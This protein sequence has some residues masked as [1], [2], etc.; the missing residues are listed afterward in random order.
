MNLPEPADPLFEIA[1]EE[2]TAERDRI[3]KR[4]KEQG[5][6]GAAAEI[7]ALKRPSITAY[8]LNLVARRDSDLIGSLLEADERM[9]TAKSRAD[10]DGAKAD[11]QKAISAISGKAI[12]VLT[13]QGRSVTPQVKERLTETLLAVATDDP[14]RELLEHGRLLKEAKAGAFGG[15]VVVF[16]AVEPDDERRK[17]NQR[18]SRLR[19]EGEAKLM[20]AKK[21]RTDSD[22]ARHEAD[23]LAEA[24]AAAAERA[25][26]MANLARKAEEVGRSKLAEAD[27]LESR[28]R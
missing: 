1:P 22:R 19:A 9:R 18:V 23:E 17:L 3:A 11:R 8:A 24:S 6:D 20:E 15:P 28:P 10:M 27:E 25:G 5:D 21:A 16:E 26:K 7:K 12:S 4:L 2:F 13:G 14:T